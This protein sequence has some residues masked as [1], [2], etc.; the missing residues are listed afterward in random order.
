R[1]ERLPA[2][3][4]SLSTR[5]R[6]HRLYAHDGLKLSQENL[7]P[8]ALDYVAIN[9][10]TTFVELFPRRQD[11]RYLGT[12]GLNGIGHLE[13]GCSGKIIIEQNSVVIACKNHCQ[14]LFRCA[15][16]IAIESTY[17]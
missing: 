17:G 2:R 1:G 14:R 5:G 8:F 3:I 6:V 15:G 16:Q 7:R 13:A 10:I 11:D 4:L 12:E 9:R